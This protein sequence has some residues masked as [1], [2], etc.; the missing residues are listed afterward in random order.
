MKNKGLV[1]S[2]SF[3]FIVSCVNYNDKENLYGMWVDNENKITFNRDGTCNVIIKNENSMFIEITGVFQVDFT[4]RPVPLTIRGIS[5][6]NHPLHTILQFKEV[7][8]LVIAEFAPR[9]KLRPLSFD[10]NTSISFKRVK[11]KI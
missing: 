6:L 3:C 4:K 2:L 10:H 5:Q 11:Q 8:E 7:D 9:W 1:I